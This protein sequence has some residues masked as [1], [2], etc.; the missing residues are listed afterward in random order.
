MGP[1]DLA[2]VAGREERKLNKRFSIVFCT[3]T[4]WKAACRSRWAGSV[5]EALWQG[6]PAGSNG[7]VMRKDILTIAQV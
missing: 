4:K 7:F 2:V 3:L 6:K 5:A 1:S